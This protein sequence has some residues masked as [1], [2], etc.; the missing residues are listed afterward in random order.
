MK[1]ILYLFVFICLISVVS[2]LPTGGTS[3]ATLDPNAKLIMAD[4]ILDNEAQLVI[5]SIENKEETGI[6]IIETITENSII[7]KT[8]KTEYLFGIFAKNRE[9]K[10]EA[11]KTGE[12]KRLTTK[13]LWAE[14]RLWS[15]IK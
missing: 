4:G 2:A 15:K 13:F 9:V 5:N 7:L 6:L 14:R 3:S 11:F 10:F 8:V 1:Q 12:V